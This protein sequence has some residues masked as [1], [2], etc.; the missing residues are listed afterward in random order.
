M[1]QASGE[2][3]KDLETLLW[4]AYAHEDSTV[5]L[6]ARHQLEDLGPV[7]LPFLLE[8]LQ[9]ED[10]TTR[11]RAASAL[12]LIKDPQAVEPLIQA[13]KDESSKV[14][15]SVASVLGRMSDQRAIKPLLELLK[16]ENKD[17]RGVAGM[18]LGMLKAVEA[19]EPLTA[20]LDDKDWQTRH[21]T[22]LALA[23][24]QDDR[25]V[26]PIRKGLKDK[27]REVR[28]VASQMLQGLEIAKLKSTSN[29]QSFFYQA[30]Y[31]QDIPTL[32]R[33]LQSDNSYLR[34][35]A[36]RR[37]GVL[38]HTPAVPF[39]LPFLK[40]ENSEVREAVA[41]ALSQMKDKE[42]VSE[43]INILE[44]QAEVDSVR[45]GAVI[46]L[47]QLRDER[48][49][50]ALLDNINDE[51]LR[52]HV[53]EA[54]GN[55]KDERAVEALIKIFRDVTIDGLLLEAVTYAL[56]KA[57]KLAVLPLIEALE[58]QNDQIRYQAAFA[59]GRIKNK[60]ALPTL[61]RLQE[62]DPD[63]EVRAIASASVER[64]EKK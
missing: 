12:G 21:D 19:I 36:I 7:A 31:E 20:F 44:N 14:R 22:I 11:S 41:V 10:V 8:K 62:S 43:L 24:M 26:E 30:Q 40:D 27:H 32:M 34:T 54:L 57:G 35:L 37:L 46:A 51:Y 3:Q 9:Q 50:Q 6:N 49:I 29:N 33:N 55:F 52:E 47:G 64:I 42:A 56:I 45:R 53:I 15:L 2:N 58:A 39:L 38:G 4:K 60:Q 59:L 17:I 1:S 63:P 25:V 61:R 23:Q 18:S 13:L 5:R 48:A 16:D 28:K